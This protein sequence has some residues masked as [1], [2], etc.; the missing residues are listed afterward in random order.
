M[1][2]RERKASGRTKG[3]RQNKGRQNERRVAGRKG[4]V[5]RKDESKLNSLRGTPHVPLGE[6]GSKTKY[7]QRATKETEPFPLSSPI[8]R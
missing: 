8:A 7:K 6:I 1:G 3:G 5:E 2:D 4:A